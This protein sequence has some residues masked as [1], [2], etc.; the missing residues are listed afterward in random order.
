M[1]TAA[2]FAASVATTASAVTAAASASAFAAQHVQC[3]LDF[4]VGGR[5]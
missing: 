4:F 2:T 1:A 5:A 3:L